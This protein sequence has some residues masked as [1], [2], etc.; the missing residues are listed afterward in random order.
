M[1]EAQTILMDAARVGDINS[2]YNSIKKVP[3]ILDHI[4][5]TPFVDSPM[6]IA[7]SAGRAN[8]A[9]EIFS[10]KSSF[11]RKLNPD[12]LSPLHLAL[13]NERFETVRRVIKFG[14]ELIRVKGRVKGRQPFLYFAAK[15][16]NTDMLAELLYMVKLLVKNDLANKN[17]KNLNGDTALDIAIRLQPGD[18][19]KKL[20]TFYV[21]PELH[22]VHRL[23]IVILVL[24]IS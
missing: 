22:E 10:L 18:A 3:N 15:T 11:G 21:V 6:H 9:I 5:D 20:R 8:F 17:E 13:Q 14:K 24:L 23:L 7:A 19:K 1:E 16:G 4:D 2:L 12:G